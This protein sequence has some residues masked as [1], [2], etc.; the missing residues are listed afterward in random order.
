MTDHCFISYSTADALDF[1]RKLAN[2][3]QGGT[4]SIP[5]WFDKDDL[6]P[7]DDWDTQ[8]DE[9][10]KTCKLVLFVMSTDSVMENSVCKQEWSRALSYKK[11]IIPL[12]LHNDINAPFRLGDRQRI[13]FRSR[14]DSGLARLRDHI[15]WID[16]PEGHLRFL[17]D[18]LA[19]AQR[20]LHRAKEE[21]QPRIQAEMADLKKEIKAYEDIN[22]DPDRAKQQT[23]RN[24]NAG[25][26]RDRQPINLTDDRRSSK[27]VNPRPGT[28]PDYFEGRLVETEEITDFLR[29][30][31]QRILTINGRAGS[32]KTVLACRLL[33]FLENGQFPNDLGEFTV[34]GIVYLSEIGNYKINVAN[35]FS[36]LLQLL[37]LQE[38]NKI[39]QLYKEGKVPT[40]EKIRALLAALPPEPVILL[41]DN[42]EDLLSS[43]DAIKDQELEAALK[44][45]L[46]ADFH[47]LKILITTRILPRQLSLFEP[48]RQHILHLEEGLRSPFAENVLRKIDKDGRTGFRDAP[49]ELLG[50]VKDATLGYPRALESLYAILRVDRYSNVE[51]LLVEGL[52]ETVVEKF[53]GEA[54]SRL[55]PTSQKVMQTLAVYNRPVSSAAVDFAL[56][57]HVPGINSSPIL[58][59]L[60]S[61]H[62]VRRETKRYFLHP[63]D[64]DYALSRMPQGDTSKRIGQGARARTWTQH[65]LT[66]RAADYFAEIR[67]QRTEWKKLEDITAQLS[68]FDLRCK[69]QDYDA[70]ANLLTSIDLDYLQLWGHYRLV[71]DL[72]KKLQ[73]RINDKTLAR[74]SVGNLGS[75]YRDSGKISDALLCYNQAVTL[76]RESNSRQAE[77]LWLGG[78]GT[79]YGELGETH[80]A[81]EYLE[82]AL[83]IARESESKQH[84]A[85]ALTNLANLYAEVGKVHKSIE[86]YEKSMEIGG[87][88]D[89]RHGEEVDL[90]NLGNRYFELGDLSKAIEYYEK[91]MKIAL[92]LGDRKGMSIDFENMGHASLNLEDYQGAIANYQQAIQIVDEISFPT[93]QANAR[94]GLA[95]VYLC[96]NDLRNARFAIEAAIQY[97]VPRA[98][99]F[100]ISLC[101]IIALRQ[102]DQSA[103]Y[104]TFTRAVAQ[105]YELLAKT[106]DYY[107]ALDAKG[108]ALCGLAICDNRNH[109]AD[110]IQAFHAARKIAPH[111]GIVKRVLRLFEEVVKCDKEGILKDVRKAVEGNE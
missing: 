39:E 102:G 100:L 35:F 29:N 47:S 15:S 43:D 66:L 86:Y 105:A 71:I 21:D 33:K 52:P 85:V 84:Q 12:W 5:V 70:A 25:L 44:A 106:P 64:R 78:L 65:S 76:A 48:A 4:P 91:A 75:A 7:G 67:K 41:L 26:E 17:K 108:L 22:K 14:F 63:A 53:V 57:L 51:E 79:C 19:D 23:R 28:I 93:V 77:G 61:M 34:G 31:Y 20:D 55:D 40:D 45:I 16:S 2:K 36:G 37:Q 18:R 103:A 83:I 73:G 80:K 89:D 32:G 88:I 95:H 69:A 13:D 94:A 54:F 68:E 90:S 62:F 30:D 87:E 97:D 110:A 56:Q 104:Q 72:H 1:A 92:E 111:A 3:L 59:R 58:E 99:H 42:F 109:V 98:N 101:G 107:S 81:I 38:A 49:D 46:Q 96:R 10:L 27:Y 50:R 82:Q 6:N 60:V 24:I 74:I 11:P 9:A 8:I